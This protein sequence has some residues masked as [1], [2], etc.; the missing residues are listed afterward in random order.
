MSLRIRKN[1]HYSDCLLHTGCLITDINI[2]CYCGRPLPTTLG[3]ARGRVYCGKCYKEMCREEEYNPEFSYCLNR[4]LDRHA[5]DFVDR[6]QMDQDEVDEYITGVQD[7]HFHSDMVNRRKA[8]VQK[9]AQ[10]LKWEEAKNLADFWG[11]YDPGSWHDS[12]DDDSIVANESSSTSDTVR[13]DTTALDPDMYDP[14]DNVLPIELPDLDQEPPLKRRRL[15]KK[16]D[17][18]K[19]QD[20]S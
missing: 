6:I 5:I 11:A 3:C 10:M 4:R 13:Y 1:G 2:K 9:T 7:C 16:S 17:K 19:K 18:D 8:E 12:D 14:D 15:I 20:S